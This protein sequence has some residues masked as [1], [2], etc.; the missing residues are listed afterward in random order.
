MKEYKEDLS[1]GSVNIPISDVIVTI[2]P[3]AAFLGA[4]FACLLIAIL[5]YHAYVSKTTLLFAGIAISSILNSFSNLLLLLNPD[6][7]VES[8]S[9]MYGTLSGVQ[10]DRLYLPFF[11]ILIT[12]IIVLLF[13]RYLTAL[14]L[15]DTL[16]TSLGIRVP[17]SRIFFLILCAIM[18]GGVV[19]FAGLLGFVGLIVPHIARRFVGG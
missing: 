5:S 3:F 9:F 16:A 4:F 12:L 7:I 8:H 15:R 1:I 19:C 6:I 18:A 2:F 14:S 11:L 17:L 10:M 13:C